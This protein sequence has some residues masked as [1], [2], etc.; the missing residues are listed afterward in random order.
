MTVGVS[1]SGLGIIT[2]AIT[3]AT[4]VMGAMVRKRQV[5]RTIIGFGASSS[6]VLRNG[7][8][9]T[10]FSSLTTHLANLVPE[11]AALAQQ[12][13]AYPA[14]GCRRRTDGSRRRSP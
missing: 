5:A 14:A 1:L 12:H 8:D 11:L 13:V 2:L 6:D 3:F 7:W 4:P 10:S 9:G